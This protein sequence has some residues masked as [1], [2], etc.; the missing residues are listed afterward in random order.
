M[1]T[2]AA[3]KFYELTPNKI[4]RLVSGIDLKQPVPD[5]CRE[6]GGNSIDHVTGII[7]K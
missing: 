6:Q 4:G 1:S 3:A 7:C 5:S 2:T